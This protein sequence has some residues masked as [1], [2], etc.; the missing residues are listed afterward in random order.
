MSLWKQEAPNWSWE[1]R[2]GLNSAKDRGAIPS[3]F[4]LQ[5]LLHICFVPKESPARVGRGKCFCSLTSWW[6]LRQTQISAGLREPVPSLYP[7]H[8]EGLCPYF[9]ELD[10]ARCWVLNTQHPYLHITH[11]WRDLWAWVLGLLTYWGFQ[12]QQL[13]KSEKH[14]CFVMSP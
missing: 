3:F 4:P 1:S 14:I 10:P 8:G 5:I 12:E 7:H 9:S 6:F 13:L 2:C 11:P